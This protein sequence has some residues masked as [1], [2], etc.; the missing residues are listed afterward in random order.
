[1]NSISKQ[2]FN[3]GWLIPAVLPLTQLGGRALFNLVILIYFIWGAVVFIYEKTPLNK[4]Y[5][6]LFCMLLISY[7]LS[8]PLAADPYRALH[9]WINYFV[10]A[11]VF[12]ITWMVLEKQGEAAAQ[13]MVKWLALLGMAMVVVAYGQ[14]IYLLLQSGFTPTQQLKED[15]M[16]YLLPFILLFFSRIKNIEVR[17]LGIITATSAILLYVFLSEGRAAQLAVAFA[18]FLYF[19]AALDI[20]WYI[21]CLISFACILVV[22]LGNLETFVQLSGSEQGIYDVMNRFTSFRWELWDHALTHAPDWNLIG[23]GMGNIRYI[24][25][26]VTLSSGSKVAHLH[27]FILDLWFETG[28]LGLIAFLTF[29]TSIISAAAKRLAS[30]QFEKRMIAGAALAGSGAILLAGLF[31]FSYN[32]RQFG[33]YLM[34]CLALLI[35]SS[36]SNT[37]KEHDA[38]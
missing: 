8:I 23:Y 33:V 13:H 16:P 38:G 32:S 36:S 6:F 7:S 15:S 34:L 10:M 2:F 20:R 3:W 27:N 26:I 22:A 25:E 31:S 12:P 4:R 5:L 28:W 30:I 29:I 21:A 9:K 11:S 35:W 37:T 1:M 18:L 24:D 19:I 14:L 17:W